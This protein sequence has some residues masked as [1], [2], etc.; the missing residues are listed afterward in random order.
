MPTRSHKAGRKAWNR[1]RLRVSLINPMRA[2]GSPAR[3]SGTTH[4]KPPGATSRPKRT[5]TSSAGEKGDSICAL[6]RKTVGTPRPRARWK[7]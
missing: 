7:R 1:S 3:S 5:S 6:W 2:C 4:P